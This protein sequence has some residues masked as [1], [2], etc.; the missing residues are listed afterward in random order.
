MAASMNAHTVLIVENSQLQARIIRDHIES[1]TSFAVETASS[2]EEVRGIVESDRDSIFMAVLNLNLKDAPDG[3]AV[4]FVLSN[5]IPCIVLTSTFDEQIRNRF[6][7]KNVLDYFRKGASEDMDEMV[8][9]LRRI[10]NNS[11]IKVLVVDDN[12]TARK[13]MRKLLE[14]QN[15][16]VMEAKDGQEAFELVQDN[17]DI[18]LLLTDYEMPRMDGFELVSKVREL[19]SRD[20]L[21][22]IGVS[23]HDSGAITAKFLK[24]G[25]NDFLKKPFEVEEFS[26][27]VTNNLNELERIGGIKDVY[28]KDTLTGFHNLPYFLENG[29]TMYT[30][31]AASGNAPTVAYF[32]LD[33]VWDINARFGWDAGS[34][35]LSKSA[36]LLEQRSMGWLLS[37]RSENGFF[38]MAEDGES[39]RRDL[40]S[41]Q[42]AVAKSAVKIGD[43][44]FEVTAS[45]VMT[46]PPADNL[47]NA[48]SKLAERILK[49]QSGSK[50]AFA[51]V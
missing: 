44:R 47:D 38:V 24:R 45:F 19:H 16:N 39:L 21:A 10:H 14:R 9:L 15:F 37:A 5:N 22:I 46:G 35:A 48:M 7:E 31:R 12:S 32:A 36:G 3:E 1:V 33:G 25:T 18:R 28:S 26:W 50:G 27:R 11:S 30:G 20:K 6:I 13:I 40:E 2:L 49:V 51:L 8:D 29:R 42:A 23:G 34:A 17:P 43:Q 4:D 41:A